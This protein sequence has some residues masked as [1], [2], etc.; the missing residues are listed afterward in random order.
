M[1]KRAI[2]DIRPGMVLATGLTH[3]GRTLLQPGCELTEELI[4]RLEDMGIGELDVTM[5]KGGPDPELLER[6]AC[7]VEPYFLYT[8][9]DN[10]AVEE[11]YRVACVRCAQALGEGQELPDE[12]T[13]LAKDVEHMRDLFFKGEG[14]PEDVVEDEV[15]LHSFP[16][17]YFRIREVLDAESS[18]ARDIARVVSTDMS[19]S[20]RLLKLVNSP[21]YGFPSTIDS[22]SRAI[23]L[24]GVKEL[25]TLAL[26]ISTINFFKDIPP[27]LVDMRTFWRHSISCGLVAK[28]I[29]TQMRG[30]SKERFFTAG[31]LHDIGK[32]LMYKKMPYG[33]VQALIFARENSLPQAD[34]EEQ[35]L[36]F[37]HTQ[38]GSLLLRQWRFPEPLEQMIHWHH[39][40]M[41]APS[42]RDTA[43][44]HVADA[45]T[46][47]LE[48]ASGGL[49]VVPGLQEGAW[50]CLGLE[51]EVL[52]V[53]MREY[54][55]QIQPILGAFFD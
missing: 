13:R 52:W 14:G 53:V 26:G 10:P 2:G 46:N 55:I 30:M 5:G 23:A 28:I 12:R 6:A 22:I 24:I 17:I 40:P 45:V 34:A 35:V 11:L 36:G 47:A 31:L 54:D 29:A 9:H 8:D 44:V 16:D 18:S 27:E 37:D 15:K 20:A 42:K 3:N 1:T 7:H 33:S 38:V 32:L 19:L 4:R 41:G 50:E 21:F 25:S 49:F 48:I 39:E 51:P 43:A